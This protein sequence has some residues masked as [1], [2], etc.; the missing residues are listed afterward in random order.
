[1]LLGGRVVLQK[2]FDA[3][4]CNQLL[5]SEKISILFGVP[6]TMRMM[7]EA[8]SFSA[9]D[10]ST[11]RFAIFGGELC[12][13]PVIEAYAERGVAMRQ[14]YG[15]TEAGPNCFSLPAADAVRK[16]GSIGFPNFHVDVRLQKDD[17]SE[18]SHGEVGELLMRGPHVFS[19]Y[20]QDPA[21]TAAVLQQGWL[22]TGDLMTRDEEGYY[23]VVGRKKD[24]YVSGG[25]NVYPAQ[26]ERT[27]QTHEAVALAAVVGK[28][29]SKWG[30]SGC[31]FVQLDTGKDVSKQELLIW[32]KQHLASFQW[33]KD[34]VIVKELPLG[35]SG[36]IDKLKLAEQ[37]SQLPEQ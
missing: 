7:W 20:W 8:E 29:D 5:G 6:T 23:Y 17:G 28:P 37:A 14:G 34:L 15:L 1:M 32:C 24:M 11:V 19:G 18:A 30:E 36:K 27:L 35:T 22:A 26:V 12:P 9:A 2:R 31:A 3:D 25:E 4:R 13:L 16:Q 33:P 10:F 21:E